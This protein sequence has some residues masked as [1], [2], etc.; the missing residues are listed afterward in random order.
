[1]N[2]GTKTNLYFESKAKGMPADTFRVIG[3]KGQEEISRPFRF[4]IELASERPDIDVE[5]ILRW[6]AFLAIERDGGIRRIH[7]VLGE[8]EQKREGPLDL[9]HYRAVL[10]PRLWLLSM[11]SQNQIYQNKSVPQIIEEEL[12]G[13]R[14]KG[15]AEL[16]AAGLTAE[17]FELRLTR[18]YSPREYTVQY[19]ESDLDFISRLMEHE[20]IFYFFEHDDTKEKII[21]TDNNIHFPAMA[22]ES[23][24]RYRPPS[25]MAAV[26]EESVQSISC[27]SRRMPKK[28]ILKD[29]NY[30]TP[31]VPLQGEAA[32]DTKGHG[33]IS[34]YGNHFKKPEEG[35]LLAR[36]RAE[37]I[38]C[39]QKVFEGEGDCS[40][41]RPGHRYTLDE[42]YREDFNREYVIT[43]VSHTGT[44]PIAGASGTTD[45]GR[46]QPSYCNEF[47]AIPSDV[48]FR[49]E[50]RTPKPKLYGIMH[51]HVDSALLEDRAEIDQQGR[52]K[53]VMPFDL[54]GAGEGKASRFI[55][56][57][58]PYGGKNQGMHFPLHK[59][60]EVIWACI[61][62]D[63]DRP[64]I[65]GVVPNPLNPS[66]VTDSNYTK[67]VIRTASGS[68]L[69]FNDGPGL[70]ALVQKVTGSQ[71]QLQ[72]HY[73]K[74][75]GGKE[76][77]YHKSLVVPDLNRKETEN[78]GQRQDPF[79]TLTD[80]QNAN[81]QGK[82]EEQHQKQ[83]YE[84]IEE[85]AGDNWFRVKVP[86]YV[87]KKDSY[88]R[89]GK[90]PGDEN[91][92]T[93]IDPKKLPD[94]PE[95]G[96]FDYT[97]GVHTSIS[98]PTVSPTEPDI[99]DKPEDPVATRA[100]PPDVDNDMWKEYGVN[101]NNK[102]LPSPYAEYEP[103]PGTKDAGF[104]RPSPEK[105]EIENVINTKNRRYYPYW[106]EKTSKR[107][108]YDADPSRRTWKY[109][110]DVK[111]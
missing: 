107:Q 86:N 12:K 11:S 53:V 62:G 13:T 25:G 82:L 29:Y 69:E 5:E 64:I 15:P 6:P 44:Q 34:E 101:I 1:M 70:G 42:H 31:H 51:A 46:E 22:E 74:D 19:Q 45:E 84:T 73:Q 102:G 23:T 108:Q 35:V 109:S 30:R 43:G 63:P 81:Y 55:R 77:N 54:S 97:D 90:D 71:L 37:E 10:V 8:F 80:K 56:M 17:D 66:V 105:T 24:I 60:T 94:Q 28:V 76:K 52:Y 61:D 72:Q 98:G 96:W 20:G 103:E 7:G 104:W 85:A 65:L 95:A 83:T 110:Y 16:A 49:P 111:K 32:V 67:N 4:E 78:S 39:R 2:M 79:V 36:I 3:F 59:G 92:T 21:I 9:Y 41:F 50:R 48:P 14:N 93:I 88:L 40:Q 106:D 27:R 57:A 68:F 100:V 18:K 87:G 26:G 33:L 89:L 38:R 58:Q 47:T 91:E 99:Y 75:D